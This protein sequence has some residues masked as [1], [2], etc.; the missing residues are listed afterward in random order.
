MANHS[1]VIDKRRGGMGWDGYVMGCVES[2]GGA[3]C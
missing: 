1:R 2:G 3:A